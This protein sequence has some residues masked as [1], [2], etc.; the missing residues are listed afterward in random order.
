MSKLALSLLLLLYYA[1]AVIIRRRKRSVAAPAHT[2]RPRLTRAKVN[3]G[4]GP[5]ERSEINMGRPLSRARHPDTP[6]A[7]V[8]RLDRAPA[9]PQA[10]GGPTGGGPAHWSCAGAALM[11]R[12]ALDERARLSHLIIQ[13]R[14]DI[15]LSPAGPNL[16]PPVWPHPVGGGRA[17]ACRRAGGARGHA[18]TSA[19]ARRPPA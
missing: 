12:R 10:S 17:R 5:C 11:R 1:I 16:G 14:F 9:R 18:N 13:F 6:P 3:T 19:R 8:G 15:I 7:T 2:P 4:A